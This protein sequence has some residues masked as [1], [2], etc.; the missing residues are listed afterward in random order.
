MIVVAKVLRAKLLVGDIA[1]HV[2][3]KTAV[4]PAAGS[5]GEAVEAVEGHADALIAL[6]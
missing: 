4:A 6:H 2:I 5:G 1:Q 3:A